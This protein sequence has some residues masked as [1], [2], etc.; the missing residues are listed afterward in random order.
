MQIFNHLPVPAIHLNVDG[1]ML[2][3]NDQAKSL[4]NIHDNV[5]DRPFFTRYIDAAELISFGQFFNKLLPQ[6]TQS[7]STSLILPGQKSIPVTIDASCTETGKRLFVIHSNVSCKPVCAEN[8]LR[9]KMLDA[10]YQYNPCGI[11]LVNDCMEMTS[12]N[13]EFIN[14]WKIPQHI[15]DSRDEEASLRSVLDKLID[16]DGFLARVREL[17]E[18]RDEIST[19]E[20]SLLDG[21][22]LYRHTYPIYNNDE[23]LG[24][25]W[26]FLDI[27]SLKIAQYQVEKQQIFQNAILEHIQDG[28]I[29]CD[30]LGNLSHFNRAS[31]KLYSNNHDAAVPDHLDQL[32]VLA[33]DEHTPLPAQANPLAMALAGER[34]NNVEVTI[35]PQPG[36]VHSFRV[37]GQAMHDGYGNK[38]GAVIS[39]HDITDLNRVKEQL[40]YMAYHDAL[41]GLPNRRLF[42]DL[43][44]QSLK[45]P[46]RYNQHVAVLF[47]DLDNF[48]RV[49]DIHGHSRGDMMLSQVADTLQGCLRESDILC[50]WGGDEFV[51][52][53]LESAGVESI[54]SVAEKICQRVLNCIEG[55][56]K[57]CQITV[58]IG[59]SIYPTHGSEPDLLI[60][61]ADM[62]MYRAKKVGKNRCELFSPENL[63]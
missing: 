56:Q 32:K 42:H 20:I 38:L 63:K 47:L 2:N 50:R 24:R 14:I 52:G 15:Q 59:I 34:V 5:E 10:Q 51:I 9:S 17:Y 3:I 40:R 36:V 45:H 53:L 37:N 28:I 19:D 58:S 12:F 1:R 22:V 13:R 18:K 29:A 57:E 46:H 30:A 33:A 61:N 55:E 16:P 62:A 31:R 43:L 21:R 60:R 35:M 41:T 7:Y 6:I 8:C 27:T 25:V 54:M 49:N 48:K 23:Y 44:L 4:L 11:L 26:Y 39:L